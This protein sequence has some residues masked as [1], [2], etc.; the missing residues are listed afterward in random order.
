MCMCVQSSGKGGLVQVRV[1]V[2][3]SIAG[4]SGNFPRAEWSGQGLG[5]QS[6]RPP[7]RAHGEQRADCGAAFDP[8]YQ[9]LQMTVGRHGDDLKNSKME[10]ADLNRTIQRLQAEIS[11]VKK[12]VRWVSRHVTSH[13][14]LPDGAPQTQPPSPPHRHCPASSP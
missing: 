7:G 12:Q 3:G 2:H 14:A 10:I 1:C 11:N 8:Q 4:L 9:E 5:R 6:P 13:G